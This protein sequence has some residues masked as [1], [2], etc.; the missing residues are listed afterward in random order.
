MLNF[1]FCTVT[2]LRNA[3]YFIMRDSCYYVNRTHG[4]S[5]PG[6]ARWGRSVWRSARIGKSQQ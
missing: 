1:K 4:N 2:D 5:Q 6:R 3:I